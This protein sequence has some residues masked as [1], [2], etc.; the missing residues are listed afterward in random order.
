MLLVVHRFIRCA[1]VLFCVFLVRLFHHTTYLPFL[2]IPIVY[3]LLIVLCQFYIFVRSM[4][5]PM[6]LSHV[7]VGLGGPM[8]LTNTAI[9]LLFKCKQTISI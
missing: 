5:A 3:E 7:S 9:K 1:K 4:A 8:R 6:R 2:N